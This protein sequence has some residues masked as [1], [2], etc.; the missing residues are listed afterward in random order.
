MQNA[1]ASSGGS[2]GGD[3]ETQFIEGVLRGLGA[4]AT[5]ANITFMRAWFN[6]EGTAARNNP[7]ATTIGGY[8]GET[9]FNSIGVKNYAS[10]AD[11]I[12]ATV[13]T[14]QEGHY[15]DIVGDLKA[16]A[17]STAKR[18]DGLKIWSSGNLSSNKGYWSLAGVSTGSQNRAFGGASAPGGPVTT[19]QA[20][21]ASGGTP[22]QLN[23]DSLQQEFGWT[24]AFFNS[25]PELKPY[26]QEAVAKG[27][28]NEQLVASVMGTKWFRDNSSTARKMWQLRATDP[29]EY[30]QEFNRSLADVQSQAGT[31]GAVLSAN[32][33][34]TIASHAMWFAWDQAQINRALGLYVNGQVGQG[35]ATE[36]QLRGIA[37]NNG[38]TVSP[39]FLR[40]AAQQIA[41]GNQTMDT[42]DQLL[43]QQAASAFP[44]FSAQIL[45]GQNMSDLA[46]AYTNA[47]AQ[48]LEKD[49]ST[50]TLFDPQIRQALTARDD[51]GNATTMPLWQFENTVRQDP[52]WLQTDNARQSLMSTTRSVLQQFGL[53]S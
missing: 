1:A 30:N 21:A 3:S 49:P 26:F 51:K 48:L 19:S 16:G 33:A 18:Y 29:S 40:Q 47:K 6:R 46:S 34:R 20:S 44:T 17:A 25:V 41:T 37:Q 5:A 35:A 23:F 22:D 45:A 4:P 9:T 28:T 39:T 10:M 15:V 24:S 52:Q 14:L 32:E 13:K 43:R 36:E 11:G 31:L 2:C 53:G 50:V 42:Y 7:M 38:I 27:W 12:S 8:A